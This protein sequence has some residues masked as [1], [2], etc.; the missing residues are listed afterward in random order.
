[1]LI[2]VFKHDICLAAK[3]IIWN[4][5]KCSWMCQNAFCLWT[6][7]LLKVEEA[8]WTVLRKHSFPNFKESLNFL[9]L[10]SFE[11]QSSLIFRGWDQSKNLYTG[12]VRIIK[13]YGSWCIIVVDYLAEGKKLTRAVCVLFERRFIFKH[14]YNHVL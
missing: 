11:D 4:Q 14:N 6:L 7:D 9:P 2:E 10:W 5:P 1:M 13:V 3:Q 8:M 12:K